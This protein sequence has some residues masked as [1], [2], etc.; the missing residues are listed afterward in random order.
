M[1]MF[2]IKVFCDGQGAVRRGIPIRTGLVFGVGRFF[3]GK[4]CK[5][6]CSLYDFVGKFVGCLD[7]LNRLLG[8]VEC[9]LALAFLI[10]STKNISVFG[11][12]VVKHLTS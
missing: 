12:K 3:V 2:Y 4:M 7:R 8:C 1:L 5:V 10:F 6:T 9:I 11:Y